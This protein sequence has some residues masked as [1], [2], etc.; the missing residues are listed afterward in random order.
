MQRLS[1]VPMA[2]RIEDYAMIGD[3]HSAA[4]VGRDGS[5]D[6]LCWPRFDSDA[7]FAAL[8]GDESHGRWRI[9][10]TGEARASRAYE[11]D[12]LILVTRYETADGDVDIVDFMPPDGGERS[13]L[14]RL[15][16][17]RRGRVPMAMQLVLRFGYG[18]A[19]PWVTRLD[20]GSLRAVAGPDMVVLRTPTPL[21]GEGFT[22]VAE[23]SVSEGDVIP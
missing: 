20:D 13:G 16:L 8:L 6:W 22:T 17:G 4:L 5:I 12:T 9:A 7:C 21:R 10:P 3:C 14:V 1:I 2:L 11:R 15:V 18:Q 23:F 19:V